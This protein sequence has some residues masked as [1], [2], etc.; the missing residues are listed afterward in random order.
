MELARWAAQEVCTDMLLKDKTLDHLG[1][2]QQS[3]G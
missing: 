1:S 3:K 2:S